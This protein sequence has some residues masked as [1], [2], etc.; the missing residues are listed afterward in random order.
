MVVPRVYRSSGEGALANYDW[1]DIA[2]GLGYVV[3]YGYKT[4]DGT[5]LL[6]NN[7][8]YSDK[9]GETD[10]FAG[11]NPAIGHTFETSIFNLPKI[12][13]GTA[14]INVPFGTDTRDTF[15]SG[16]IFHWDGTSNIKLG[17]GGDPNSD[18]TANERSVQ[19]IPIDLPKTLIKKGDK[20][21]VKI[22]VWNKNPSGNDVT[23]LGHDPKNRTYVIAG[24]DM[25]TTDLQV[26]L[27][28]KIDI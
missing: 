13:E 16:A 10:L 2:N 24:D 7:Q 27:P 25:T 14:I 15:C 9:I 26:H 3:F 5:Y 17:S 28:F 23:Y 18:I 20:I 8:V 22:D 12:L 4:A 19:N 21:K 6:S 11:V 1:N